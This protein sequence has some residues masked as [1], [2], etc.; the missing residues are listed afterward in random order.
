MWDEFLSNE[1]CKD[2]VNNNKKRKQSPGLDSLPSEF[3]QTFWCEIGFIF[4]E[5]L[6]D[7]YNQSEMFSS[8]KTKKWKKN[9]L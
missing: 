8:Q 6:K 3:Y 9:Y 2:A 1:D 4:Y 7:I 5:A